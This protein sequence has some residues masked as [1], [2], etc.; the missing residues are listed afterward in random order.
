[1]RPIVHFQKLTLPDTVEADMAH[2]VPV[3][4]F[5]SIRHSR[6]WYIHSYL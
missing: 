5:N 2:S 4:Q 1:M 3:Q 6:S